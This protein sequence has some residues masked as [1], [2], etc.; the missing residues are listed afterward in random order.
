MLRAFAEEVGAGPVLEVGCGPGRVAAHL[1]GLGLDVAGLDLSPGM[2]EVARR[3][4]P[5]LQVDVGDLTALPHPDA[6]LAGVVA[7]Y[8][9]I[10]VPTAELPDAV[11]E[12]ARVLR[13]GGLLLLAFQVGDTDRVH[14]RPYGHDVPLVS[15]R[16]QPDRVTALLAA[17]GLE[18]EGTLVRQPQGLEPTPQAYL[19][20]RRLTA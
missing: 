3:E 15:H 6:S 2:V 17:S 7:W 19:T 1:A 11:A 8:S 16:L 4:H 13:P 10:H 18:L 20:A 5:G 9:L 12:L 14:D